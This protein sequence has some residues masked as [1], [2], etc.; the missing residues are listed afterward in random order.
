MP[1]IKRIAIRT[2]LIAALG[3]AALTGGSSTAFADAQYWNY[4]CDDGRACVYVKSTGQVWNIE[5]CG[6][7][8]LHDYFNYAQAHGN[9][10]QI[11]YGP[12]P[13]YPRERYDFVP[14]WS[15]RLLG[16]E[17]LATA[18]YVYC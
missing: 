2:A 3:A 1:S 17:L 12:T 6:L 13:T 10:F 9:A 8:G 16:G 14:Q 7:T 11:V 15:Q 18:V 5:H 4:K